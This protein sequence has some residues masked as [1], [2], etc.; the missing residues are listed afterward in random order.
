MIRKKD[1]ASRFFSDMERNIISKF[2]EPQPTMTDAFVQFDPYYSMDDNMAAA[3]DVMFAGG[4][5]KMDYFGG[6]EPFKERQSIGR[7]RLLSA[8]SMAAPRMIRTISTIDDDLLE[9]LRFDER[10]K[11]SGVSKNGAPISRGI[12]Q[13]SEDKSPLIGYDKRRGSNSSQNWFSSSPLASSSM[14]STNSS[15]IVKPHSSSFSKQNATNNN[16]S[17]FIMDIPKASLKRR[18]ST[19]TI[20]VGTTMSVQDNEATIKCVCVVIRAHIIEAAKRNAV[21]SRQYD[22]FKDPQ[23]TATTLPPSGAPAPAPIPSLAEIKDFFMLV[24]S[25]SQLESECIIMALIYCERMI[26]E[27]QGRF[28]VRHDNWKSMYVLLSP[29]LL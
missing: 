6:L 9:I 10:M 4:G 5:E 17:N 19:G 12:S 14:D 8:S 13:G 21:A 11:S 25:K 28:I 27:T 2:S 26:K 3:G 7:P 1:E 24:F 22:I 16:S 18:N 29:A 23:P 15:F 20:Y